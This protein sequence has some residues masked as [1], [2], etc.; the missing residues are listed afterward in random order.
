MT[1]PMPLPCV[2]CSMEGQTLSSTKA[3]QWLTIRAKPEPICYGQTVGRWQ[4]GQ[5]LT[6]YDDRDPLA[7][8]QQDTEPLARRRPASE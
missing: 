2:P 1:R 5:C 7:H 6:K 8:A 4:S 3:I